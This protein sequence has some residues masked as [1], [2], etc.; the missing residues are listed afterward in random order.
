MT[1][2]PTWLMKPMPASS[3]SAGS[4]PRATRPTL[5]PADVVDTGGS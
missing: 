5:E 3:H 1:E 4:I 2:M